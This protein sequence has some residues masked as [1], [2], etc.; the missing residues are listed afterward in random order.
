MTVFTCENNFVAML[1][2]IYDAWA[3]KLGHSNVKLQ[4]EDTLQQELFVEYR[5]ISPDEQKAQ[6]VARSIQNKIGYGA[7]RW[8]VYGLCSEEEDALDTVYRFL[9]YGF[10]KGAEVMNYL[11]IPEIQRMMQIQRRVSSQAHHFIEFLRFNEM[12]GKIY[13]AHFEPDSMV[14][15][16]VCHHFEDRMPSENFVIVDDVHRLAMVHP[17]DQQAYLKTLSDEEFEAL[18]KSEEIK[19]PFIDLWKTF[20]KAITIEERMNYRCQRNL[21]PLWMRKHATEFMS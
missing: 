2:C 13:V 8:V 16:F 19:D 12:P 21:F 15:T 17:R 3:S 11:H 1:S 4:R 20:F 18:K 10:A 14:I 5:H 7:Y 9:I 6:M